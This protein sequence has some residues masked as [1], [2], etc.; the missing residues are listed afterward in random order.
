M[1]RAAVCGAAFST[2]VAALGLEAVD[3]R[4]EIVLVDLDDAEAMARAAGIAGDV[5]R[6]AI[7]G[8][9]REIMVRALGSGI[10]FAASADAASIGPLLVTA[11]PAHVRGRTRLVVVTGARGGVGRTLLAT[12][13]AARL[14]ARVSVLLID[15][16]GSGAA[17]WWL[18]LSPGPWSEM[19]GLADELTAEHLGVVAAER[20]RLRLVGGI[21]AMPSVG[22]VAAAARA[23]TGIADAVIVD[24]PTIFDERTRALVEIADRVLLVTGDDAASTAAIDEAADERTW[25]IA[26]RCRARSLAGRAVLRELPEDA[27]AVRSAARGPSSVGGPLG[28]AYDDLAELLAI[29]IA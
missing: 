28:R 11:I 9:D 2:A 12:G 4:P 14:A 22:L 5:P 24:A 26:S 18:G 8:P 13:L 25:I 6:I 1:T 17:G 19:E 21:S 3:E 7:G 27:G 29:D 23:A 16:T 20:D 15:V 10:A